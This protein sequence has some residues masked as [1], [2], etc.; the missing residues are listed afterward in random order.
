ME[1]TGNG[2][3]PGIAVGQA[4]VMERER[5]PVFRLLLAPDAVEREV[6][7]LLRAVAASRKQL[8]AIK[9][10]LSRE[11]GA[12][13][14]YIFD[15]QLLMLE[16]PLLR[17]RAAGIVRQDHVNAEWALRQVSEQL[18]ALFDGFTDEYLKERSSDLD[19]VLGRVLLNLAGAA[20]GPSL[21]RLPGP[22]VLVAQDLTPSEAAELDWAK[23]MGIALDGGSRTY[24]TAILARSRGI[25]AVAGLRDATQRVPPGALVVLDG[26]QGRLVVEPSEPVV[27]GFRAL[28]ERQQRREISLQSTRGEPAASRDGVRVALLANAEFAE[29]AATAM[30][31]GAEGIGLF[32]SEYLLGRGSLDE[33]RQYELY[34]RLLD[35][36]HPHPVTVRVWDLGPEDIAPGGPSSPNPALGPRALRMLSRAPGAF[37]PQLRALLRAAV[38]GPLRIL[39]PFLRGASDLAE[40]RAFLAETA[41]ELESEGRVY[42]AEL[43]VG[44]MIEIPS[45][46]LTLGQLAPAADFFSIGT[47]DLIQYLLAV[48]RADPRVASL[49]EPLHPAVLA[50]LVTAFDQAR[51]AGRPV[52]VCG[53][54]A[55][56]PLQSLVL[57]GLGARELS[58][59]PTA[60]PR[61]K[62]VLRAA[63]LAHVREATLRALRLSSAAAVESHL[64]T[65][66][67]EALAAAD[68]GES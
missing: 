15:A 27:A 12:L 23:V 40:V 58:M 56:D 35:Q 36:M 53:E 21:A 25:P 37:R 5:V 61:V 8:E 44:V 66:L 10:R 67:H 55:G 22:V 30:Q 54:M 46:A 13:H 68:A 24:H 14:A 31:Y 52:G 39:F 19:D 50:L 29:E 49:Y 4:L 41:Q 34:R 65:E 59:S 43:P 20:D 60:I 28:R 62:Q 26:T 1:L 48:D 38:H 45:A 42:A 51:A 64:R 17:D 63:D 3:S 11:V 32:R 16:D 47:N 6:Q 7:R 57:A 18:H 2:V 33:E 9:A